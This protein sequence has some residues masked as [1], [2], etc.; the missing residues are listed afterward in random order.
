MLGK[1][2]KNSKMNDIGHLTVRPLPYGDS[3]M[4]S[5]DKKPWGLTPPT[6]P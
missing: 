2:K 5:S 4:K 3:D 1:T 6:L